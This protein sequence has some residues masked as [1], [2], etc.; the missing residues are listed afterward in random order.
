MDYVPQEYLMRTG[1]PHS[2]GLV[3][4]DI[5]VYCGVIENQTDHFTAIKYMQSK[6]PYGFMCLCVLGHKII[7]Y[8][9]KMISH[10]LI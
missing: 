7:S 6:L 1:L 3:V 9:I 2:F 4:Q 10:I 5:T 8:F